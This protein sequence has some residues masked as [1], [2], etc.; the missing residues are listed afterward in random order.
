MSRVIGGL[1]YLKADGI[2][3]AAKGDY[4]YNTGQ[5]K[6]QVIVGI[7][8]PHGVTENIQ[9]P[10]IEGMTSDISDV[11]IEAIKN[12]KDATVELQ[13]NNTK[14]FVLRNAFYCSEGDHTTAEGEVALRFEG[15]SGEV[16]T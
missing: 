16:V 3:I 9:V 6:R 2:S 12:I 14:T 4:S 11:D 1:A 10:F 7:D 13:L 15:L 5:M 8:E